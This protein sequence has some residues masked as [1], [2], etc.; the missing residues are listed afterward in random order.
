MAWE[1]GSVTLHGGTGPVKREWMARQSI[2]T[3]TYM[4]FCCRGVWYMHVYTHTHAYTGVLSSSKTDAKTEG[5][6]GTLSL[7]ELVI[8]VGR[9]KS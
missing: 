6:L 2:H 7:G 1:A 8:L 4:L 3:G 9:N 5:N